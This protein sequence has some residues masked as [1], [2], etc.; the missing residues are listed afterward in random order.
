M[1]TFLILLIIGSANFVSAQNLLLPSNVKLDS[2]YIQ[3]ESSEVSWTMEN[4]GAK[5]EIGKVTTEFKKLNKKDLL[6]RTTVKMKQAPEAW[7]DSTIVKISDFQPVYH[8]SFNSMRN[9]S[10]TFNKNKVTGYYLDKK[11]EKKDLINEA[12]TAAFFDSNSYPALIRFLPLNENYTTDISIFDYSPTAKKG[13]VKAYIEK[14]EKGEYNGKK[15]WI[16]KT[17][18]DIQ[19]RKTESI[20]YIDSATRKVIK[21]EINASG[22]KMVME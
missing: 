10:L 18:D 5:I 6:I 4:A 17:T 2:K 15:A 7:V 8:S 1:R 20:Y 21:Q 22:R 9:M 12:T 16:V 11:T 3:E 14:V 13:V 19:D